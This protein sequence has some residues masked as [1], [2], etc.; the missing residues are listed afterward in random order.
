MFV[1]NLAAQASLLQQEHYN[2]THEKL[3]GIAFVCWIVMLIL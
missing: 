2:S 3:S 1:R